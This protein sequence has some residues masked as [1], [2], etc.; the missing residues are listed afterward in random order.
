VDADYALFTP[1]L[2]TFVHVDIIPLIVGEKSD[3]LEEVLR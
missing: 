1:Q 2:Q 3:N